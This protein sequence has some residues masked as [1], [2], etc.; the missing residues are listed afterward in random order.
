M[1]EL[2]GIAQRHVP[3]YSRSFTVHDMSDWSGT[4][5]HEGLFRM[6]EHNVWANPVVLPSAAAMCEVLN[7]QIW[8]KQALEGKCTGRGA[9]Q[10]AG[11]P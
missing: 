9:V 11:V 8:L 6:L 4:L 7:Q 2:E 3:H 1:R 10:G 5:E